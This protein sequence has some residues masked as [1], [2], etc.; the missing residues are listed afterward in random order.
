MTRP[1]LL[2]HSPKAVRVER[3]D[4]DGDG[5]VLTGEEPTGRVTVASVTDR[6]AVTAAI[7]ERICASQ[8]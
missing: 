5:R 6:D 3:A 7:V 1:S 4:G 8:I 2:P